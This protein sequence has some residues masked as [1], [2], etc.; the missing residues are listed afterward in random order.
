MTVKE[1]LNKF[2]NL[3]FDFYQIF[4]TESA[5]I[6]ANGFHMEEVIK[7][8]GDEIVKDFEIVW[9]EKMG[10]VNIGIDKEEN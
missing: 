8:F 10:Y 5:D 1:L 9:N 2:Q 6:I 3:D 4:K 7:T